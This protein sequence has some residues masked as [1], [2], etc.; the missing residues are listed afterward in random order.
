MAG[1][2][3]SSKV[4]ATIWY[5]V[6]DDLDRDGFKCGTRVATELSLPLLITLDDNDDLDALKQSPLDDRECELSLTD[7]WERSA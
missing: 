2:F 4:D 7:V 6:R 3:C 1:L 5:D